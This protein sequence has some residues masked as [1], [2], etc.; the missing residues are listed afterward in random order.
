MVGAH[1][2]GTPVRLPA[3]HNLLLAFP[4][5]LAASAPP[6]AGGPVFP[7]MKFF[8]G[9]TE[10]QGTIKVALGATRTLNVRSRGRIEP[11]GT[12][13]LVQNVEEA[14]KPARTRTWRIRETA[15][16]RFAG[17]LSDASGPV[18][19]Q[20]RGNRLHLAYRIKGGLDADQWLT[21]GSG[22]RSA[23]NRMTVRK[24]GLVVA[25]VRE[26]IHKLD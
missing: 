13:V 19:G 9:R 4:L 20:V 3:M 5:L 8:E 15:P 10:G 18:R 24:F 17:T 21:L 6:A 25:K 12:L 22:G 26:T 23:D 1:P 14:G 2:A 11:D 7:V 16:N